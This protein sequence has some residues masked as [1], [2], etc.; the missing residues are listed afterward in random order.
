MLKLCRVQPLSRTTRSTQRV[1]SA[2][3]CHWRES[4]AES[5]TFFGP[6]SRRYFGQARARHYAAQRDQ[7]HKAERHYMTF[8]IDKKQLGMT[9]TNPPLRVICM[10]C[11]RQWIFAEVRGFYLWRENFNFLRDLSESLTLAKR[12]FDETLT[13]DA[14]NCRCA[15]VL[16]NVEYICLLLHKRNVFTNDWK[17]DQSSDNLTQTNSGWYEYGNRTYLR[18]TLKRKWVYRKSAMRHKTETQYPEEILSHDC[19]KKIQH[20]YIQCDLKGKKATIQWFQI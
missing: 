15:G 13:N 20:S 2:P 17:K 11:V 7:K 19:Y 6:F 5:F 10:R 12:Y 3:Y 4:P 14:K 1:R 18:E 16:R 9:R 8:L